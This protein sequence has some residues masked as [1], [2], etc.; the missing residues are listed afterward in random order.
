MRLTVSPLCYFSIFLFAL[1]RYLNY[2]I[3]SYARASGSSRSLGNS[4]YDTFFF[5]LTGDF[6]FFG[7]DSYIYACKPRKQRYCDTWWAIFPDACV[8]YG[9]P[10]SSGTKKETININ[11]KNTAHPRYGALYVVS[12]GWWP[13]QFPGKNEWEREWKLQLDIAFE[14]TNSTRKQF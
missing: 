9:T 14:Q 12:C 2:Q 8:T 11:A 7:Y 4:V 10:P 1:S 13:L 6:F 3:Q 5:T